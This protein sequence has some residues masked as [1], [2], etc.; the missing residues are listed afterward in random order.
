MAN[1]L[2]LRN[3]VCLFAGALF[4]VLAMQPSLGQEPQR[5]LVQTEEG[6]VA[7]ES[8]HSALPAR[9]S[10]SSTDDVRATGGAEM[11]TQDEMSGTKRPTSDNSVPK[12]P[13]TG[14]EGRKLPEPSGAATG[15][16]S[17]QS[18]TPD[19]GPIDTSV[20]VPPSS[21]SGRTAPVHDGEKGFKI[22]VPERPLARRAPATGTVSPRNAIGLPVIPRETAQS[23]AG[24]APGP[25]AASH[26]AA[27]AGPAARVVAAPN[28]SLERPSLP[29]AEIDGASMVR[30]ST[31]APVLGGPAKPKEAGINGATVRPKR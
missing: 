1:D 4:A 26:T 31:A 9:G 28:A 3:G 13:P 22:V 23:P 10:A 2:A 6:G 27:P 25:A 14:S 7:A 21:R 5:P 30:P 11:N 19:A 12:E 24:A 15:R 8:E 17:V 16:P 20:A 18:R 29:G